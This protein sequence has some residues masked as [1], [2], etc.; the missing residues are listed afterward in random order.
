MLTVS[1]PWVPGMPPDLFMYWGWAF[2][3][4][5]HL[6]CIHFDLIL[7]VSKPWVPGM[8]PDLF[9]NWGWAF[10]APA[11][12]RCEFEHVLLTK[13]SRGGWGVLEILWGS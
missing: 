11:W 2:L 12:K 13:V 3:I 4:S 6:T 8:P 10:Q 7:T 5:P 9:M 1:K